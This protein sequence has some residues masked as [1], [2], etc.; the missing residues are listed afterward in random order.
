MKRVLSLLLALCMVCCLSACSVNWDSLWELLTEQS[1]DNVPEG[2]RL[3]VHFLDVGQG[4]SIFIELPDGK[5]MLI[6]AGENYHGEGI[7]DYITARGCNAI[8]YLVA[9]HPHTDHIGSMP[10]IV[11]N[12]E[13]GAVYMPKV[14]ATTKTYESLLKAVKKKGLKIQTGK[15]GVRMIDD[16]E[17]ELTADILA[18][19]R[20]DKDNL[21]NS[22]IVIRMT[23]GGTSFLFPG[24]AESSELSSISEDISSD[25]LKA[26]HHGSRTSTT[27][28]LLKRVKPKITVISC[29]ADNDYGHPHRKVLD[30]LENT[31]CAVYRT[32]LDG[33]VTVTS[34]GT[35]L[36]VSTGGRSV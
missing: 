1:E 19:I 24:D 10:Y 26:G 32:D 29:G 36:S 3:S 7:L 14:S 27:K 22:S 4:D 21:N 23:F 30:L 13:I 34:D 35:D 16:T 28:S 5:T 20:L 11:R 17:N 33:T 2:S 12:F 6:D 15:A 31:D 25:V 9:T 8:D 18:P